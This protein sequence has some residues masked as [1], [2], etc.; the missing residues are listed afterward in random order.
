MIRAM[1]AKQAVFKAIVDGDLNLRQLQKEHRSIQTRSVGKDTIQ[2]RFRDSESWQTVEDFAYNYYNKIVKDVNDRIASASQVLVTEELLDGLSN[3]VYQKIYS[4]IKERVV[5]ETNFVTEDEYLSMKSKLSQQIQ[6]TKATLES[7]LR[8]M[9]KQRDESVR[10]YKELIA[11]TRQLKDIYDARE[12]ELQ[13]MREE[14]LKTAALG[15]LKVTTVESIF[16]K[17]EIK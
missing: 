3:E 16:D 4:A 17:Y 12:P 5:D 2:I 6:Q 8:S 11:K 15:M 14:I 10:D 9:T 13:K 7:Q 1:T